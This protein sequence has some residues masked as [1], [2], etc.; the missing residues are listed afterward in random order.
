[1]IETTSAFNLLQYVGQMSAEL[2]NYAASFH[3]RDVVTYTRATVQRAVLNDNGPSPVTNINVP[4]DGIHKGY[5]LSSLICP[6][7]IVGHAKAVPPT[8]PII[9]S[10][11]SAANADLS[12]LS[13]GSLLS[14]GPSSGNVAIAHRLPGVSQYSAEKLKVEA[15]DVTDLQRLM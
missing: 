2:N 11:T 6:V 5:A 7:P 15:R 1:M 12:L 4:S 14:L 10:S 13:H 8:F 3:R 9:G